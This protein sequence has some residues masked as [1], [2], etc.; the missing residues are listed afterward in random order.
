MTEWAVVAVM[1][2]SRCAKVRSVPAPAPR[3]LLAPRGRWPVG[4]WR[5]DISPGERLAVAH[6]AQLAIAIRGS[7]SGTQESQQQLAEASG[8]SVSTI[9]RIEAGRVWPDLRTVWLLLGALGIE[10]WPRET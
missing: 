4:P 7:R 3:D 2:P 1:R 6:V 5:R 10:E 9:G 8:V